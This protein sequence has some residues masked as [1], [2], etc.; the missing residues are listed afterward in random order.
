MARGRARFSDRTRSFQG[1]RGEA[2]SSTPNYG[3][4][5]NDERI[6]ARAIETDEGTPR[7]G[8]TWIS[9]PTGKARAVT[10]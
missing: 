5:E 8:K 2:G 1:R 6:V 4:R 9:R 7:T 10:T 3:R